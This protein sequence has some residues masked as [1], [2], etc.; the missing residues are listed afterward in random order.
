M[1]RS[2]MAAPFFTELPGAAGRTR[3]PS[4][5]I[6]RSRHP[7]AL[8]PRSSRANDRSR[9]RPPPGRTLALPR[10][11]AHLPATLYDETAVVLICCDHDVAWTAV[12]GGVGRME[13]QNERDGWD[14]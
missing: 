3:S 4:P 6:G 2:F 8:R 12:R 13:R 11:A 9:W 1:S 7:R 5:G 14:Q 10:G